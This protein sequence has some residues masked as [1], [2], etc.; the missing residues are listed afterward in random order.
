MKFYGGVR[1]GKSNK[2]LKFGSAPDY[3]PDM[4]EIC[5]S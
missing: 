2:W 3:D 1:V 5:I 4:A